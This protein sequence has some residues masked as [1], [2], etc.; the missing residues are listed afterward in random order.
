MLMYKG[1]MNDAK[2]LYLEKISTDNITSP[3]LIMHSK[4]DALVN[5]AHAMNSH[6][7]IKHSKLILLETGG[8]AMLTQLDEV[9]KNINEFLNMSR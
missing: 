8:H 1:T 5:Y 6:D 7:K 4:D 9:R 2:M 3:T